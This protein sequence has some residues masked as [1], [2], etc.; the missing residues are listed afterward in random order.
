MFGTVGSFYEFFAG[1]G[2]ARAGL[3]DRWQ[4]LFA[5][6]FDQRKA[7]TYILNWGVDHLSCG[8]VRNITTDDLTDVAGSRLG[9]F[10][11]SRPVSRRRGYRFERRTLRHFLAILAPNDSAC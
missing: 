8:D 6:D 9:V 3:G 4:C 11:V 1:A 7:A 5:N 10:P 2:M